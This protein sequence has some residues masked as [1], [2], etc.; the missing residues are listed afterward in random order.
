MKYIYSTLAMAMMVLVTTLPV[1]PQEEVL[2]IQSQALGKH[3]RPVVTFP[4]LTHEDL[5][6]CSECHHDYDESGENI[7]GDGGYCA[8]CHSAEVGDNP[9]PLLDAM[10]MQ[11]LGCHAKEI[12]ASD[13]KNI[14]QMCGQCHVRKDKRSER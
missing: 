4:H 14:P 13:N 7:G 11:C 8:D 9:V 1:F 10:H 5:I 12:T 3:E 2:E 6:D